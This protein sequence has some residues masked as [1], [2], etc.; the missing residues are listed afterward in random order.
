MHSE[1]TPTAPRSPPGRTQGRKPELG[2]NWMVPLLTPPRAYPWLRALPPRAAVLAEMPPVPGMPPSC[3][4]GLLHP[5]C[6]LR[7]GIPPT[8]PAGTADQ[9]GAELRTNTPTGPWSPGGKAGLG[10]SPMPSLGSPGQIP[11]MTPGPV[12]RGGWAVGCPRKASPGG[13]QDRQLGRGE[14]LAL[15][16]CLILGPHSA[17]L[18]AYS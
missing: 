17:V 10:L 15:V 3:S 7:P 11:V 6:H 13:L 16:F 14:G 4:P 5:H 2:E 9:S 18:R 1:L 8:W 12:G